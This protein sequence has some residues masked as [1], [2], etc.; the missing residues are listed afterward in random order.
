[1]SDPH[2]RRYTHNI[3]FIQICSNPPSSC[4]TSGLIIEW[5]QLEYI[6][7][8]TK[9]LLC[10]EF[11]VIILLHEWVDRGQMPNYKNS[12]VCNN[13]FIARSVILEF[14]KWCVCPL[15]THLCI[16]VKNA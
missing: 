15:S 11:C 12:S 16:K 8:V 3:I 7:V 5:F 9:N 1:M 13:D 6:V 4:T 14:F 2:S 10:V